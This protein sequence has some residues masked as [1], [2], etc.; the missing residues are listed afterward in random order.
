M[1]I[2]TYETLDSASPRD[3]AD[4]ITIVIDT[5]RATS[6]IVTAI[7]NG[8]KEIIPVSEVEEALSLAQNLDRDTYLLGGERNGVLIEGFD[9]SNSPLEYTSDV[10]KGKTIIL[11]TTNGTKAIKKASSAKEIIICSMLNVK[12]V[13]D[14]L[15]E[16]KM[17]AVILC[18]GTEGKGTRKFSLEDVIT[19][20][21]VISRIDGAD[22]D[23]LSYASLLLYR[24]NRH[25]LHNL[26]QNCFH[27]KYLI[28]I[29]YKDDVDFCLQEDIFDIL[30]KYYNGTIKG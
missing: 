12:A 23:D 1:R 25:D 29:G 21:A 8:C 9:L 17:D 27:Y 10:V 11:T 22:I 13:A 14:Y 4:K 24:E 18:A 20:G 15:N 30:P 16:V 5:L 3:F 19:V 2:D 26:M 6:T 7:N 28:S